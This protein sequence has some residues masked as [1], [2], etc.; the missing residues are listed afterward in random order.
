MV[1]EVEPNNVSPFLNPKFATPL[2][3]GQTLI[4]NHWNGQTDVDWFQID[5][6]QEPKYER[7]LQSV[8]GQADVQRSGHPVELEHQPFLLIDFRSSVIVG[9]T[10]I[11]IYDTAQ[12]LVGQLQ[13]SAGDRQSGQVA[14]PVTNN[15]Y[16]IQVSPQFQTGT[17][18]YQQ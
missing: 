18:V 13:V 16:A 17:S 15:I 14:I 4:G 5:L 11:R 6:S 9:S 10:Q 3:I 12:Q 2:T 1:T 7:I 8:T